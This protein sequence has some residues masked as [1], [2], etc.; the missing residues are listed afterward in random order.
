MTRRKET[1]VV[2]KLLKDK[3]PSASSGSNDNM[4]SFTNF[5]LLRSNSVSDAAQPLP[6]PTRRVKTPYFA[7]GS[8]VSLL[9]ASLA[10]P[11]LPAGPASKIEIS[12]K[13]SPAR[14]AIPRKPVAAHTPSGPDSTYKP[15]F[16][17]LIRPE[18]AQAA[19]RPSTSHG[20]GRKRRDSSPHYISSEEFLNFAQPGVKAGCHARLEAHNN[21]QQP[22]RPL[23]PGSVFANGRPQASPTQSEASKVLS[24][25]I[26]SVRKAAESVKSALAH[27]PKIS[28]PIP[29]SFQRLERPRNLEGLGESGPLNLVGL[30]TAQANKGKYAQADLELESAY[31]A[32]A[33]AQSFERLTG[34]PAPSVNAPKPAPKS[35][36]RKPA[37]PAATPAPIPRRVVNGADRETMFGDIIDAASDP[38]WQQKSQ[39]QVQADSMA[40]SQA[41]IDSRGKGKAQPTRQLDPSRNVANRVPTAGNPFVR[42]D[43]FQT[44][45]PEVL[46]VKKQSATNKTLPSAPPPKNPSRLQPARQL[47]VLEQTL[48]AGGARPSS[49]VPSIKCS[50]CGQYIEAET[51]DEHRCQGASRSRPSN[52]TTIQ[53]FASTREALYRANFGLPLDPNDDEPEVVVD[54]FLHEGHTTWKGTMKSDE[55]GQAKTH[56]GQIEGGLDGIR[57][58]QLASTQ[59]GRVQQKLGKG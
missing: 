14:Q 5:G 43:S 58:A 46:S 16:G 9:E 21:A 45:V 34:E 29:G 18:G 37:T 11:P 27:E 42:K 26:G 50:D 57:K 10:L 55:R 7:S 24:R 22:E 33:R 56:S 12:T 49:Y 48:E 39:V 28:G 51:A 53:S 41:R 54:T 32:R 44:N 38:N 47:S 13:P 3:L 35:A 6:V 25:G 4:P 19:A 20:S 40:R 23:S 52:A 17:H 36:A 8:E 59:R 2:S 15:V 31:V 30:E 1:P